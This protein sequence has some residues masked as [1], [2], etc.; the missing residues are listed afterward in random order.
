MEIIKLA[1]HQQVCSV[2]NEKGEICSGHLKEWMTAPDSVIKQL[3]PGQRLYR[4][5]RCKTA[6]M[7]P[8][9][10]HLHAGEGGVM[11]PPQTPEVIIK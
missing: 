5:K 2:K 4:C 11:L 3:K 10:N 9:Q 6:Y 8:P 1:N 7:S